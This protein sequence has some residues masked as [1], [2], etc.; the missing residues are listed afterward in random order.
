MKW[1]LL[2]GK[3][4]LLVI[5]LWWSSFQEFLDWRPIEIVVLI[6]DGMGLIGI[7]FGLAYGGGGVLFLRFFKIWRPLFVGSFFS[8]CRISRCGML[9]V[10]M[11]S[12]FRR[13]V[14]SL[15]FTDDI[16]FPDGYRSTKCNKYVPH[17]VIYFIGD[18]V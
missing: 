7:R 1:V 3:I 16:S 10:L 13:P 11:S 6:K 18:V 17:K 14:D 12:S 5:V 9:V 2:F 4:C 15:R 8:D